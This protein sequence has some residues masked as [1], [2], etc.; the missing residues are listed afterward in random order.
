MLA[1]GNAFHHSLILSSDAVAFLK[2]PERDKAVSYFRVI[3]N[4]SQPLSAYERAALSMSCVGII[5]SFVG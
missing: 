3:G 2:P 5:N 4:T 1:F